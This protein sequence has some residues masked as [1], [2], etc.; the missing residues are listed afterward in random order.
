M[1]NNIDFGT[2][3]EFSYN[4]IKIINAKRAHESFAQLFL[5]L[6]NE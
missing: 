1:R 4:Y 3:L 2:I 6:Y 5:N